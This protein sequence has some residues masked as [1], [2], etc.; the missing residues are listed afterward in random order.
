MHIRLTRKLA[1]MLNGVD[2]RAFTVG[3]V[4]QLDERYAAMLV[5]EGWAE[6]V[7][8][9]NIRATADDRQRSGRRRESSPRS[10]KTR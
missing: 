3:E 6:T 5:A 4:L 2:L 10:K 7:V 8:P 1:E 9:M